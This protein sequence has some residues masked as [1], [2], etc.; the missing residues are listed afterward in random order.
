MRISGLF[1]QEQTFVSGFFWFF[2]VCSWFFLGLSLVCPWFVP[3]LFPL[4]SWYPTFGWPSLSINYSNKYL[5]RKHHNQNYSFTS[6]DKYTVF[7]HLHHFSLIFRCV[8]ST[9]FNN[10]SLLCSLRLTPTK[11][12][13]TSCTFW[14]IRTT[15][16]CCKVETILKGSLDSIPSPSPSVKI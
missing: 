15:Y 14:T 9:C 13:I 8:F 7:S 1:L 11:R 6:G 10:K 2:L 12:L 4:C 16:L 5:K 3:G